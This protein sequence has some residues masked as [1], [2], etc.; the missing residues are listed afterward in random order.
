MA[1]R[2]L[3]RDYIKKILTIKAPNGYKFDLANYIGNP[4]YDYDYP[5][6]YKVIAETDTE[7]TKRRVYYMKYYN[8]GGG[9]LHE[10]LQRRRRVLRGNLHTEQGRRHMANRAESQERNAGRSKPIQYQ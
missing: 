8:G 6:F 9:L 4:A 2:N 7:I 5:S 1:R 3:K 10:I